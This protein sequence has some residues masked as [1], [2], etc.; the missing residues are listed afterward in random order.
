MVRVRTSVMVYTAV[1]VPKAGGLPGCATLVTGITWPDCSVFVCVTVV[2]VHDTR[3]IAGSVGW[4]PG[5]GGAGGKGFPSSSR[6][7]AS[8]QVCVA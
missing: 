3:S 8:F 1:L 5:F 7:S 2:C 4:P 6:P